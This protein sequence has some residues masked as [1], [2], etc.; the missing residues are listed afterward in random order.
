VSDRRELGLDPRVWYPVLERNPEALEPMARPGYLWIDFQG[1]S[2]HV[3][4]RHLHIR[5]EESRE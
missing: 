1:R 4:A 3:W 5:T 2:M